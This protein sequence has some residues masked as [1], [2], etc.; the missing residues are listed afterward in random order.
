MRPGGFATFDSP[1]V[2]AEGEEEVRLLDV[3]LDPADS[4][5]EVTDV[6]VAHAG[7]GRSEGET[8][9]RRLRALPQAADLTHDG[10]VTEHCSDE[11]G[12]QAVWVEL[13]QTR[14]GTVR[15]ERSRYL[16]E[17]DGELRRTEWIPRGYRLRVPV[18]AGRE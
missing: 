2:C 7:P 6:G 15:V 9:R 3:E 11:P 14:P 8:A 17:V 4:G 13:H 12:A 1:Y 18:R 10:I 16:Y 5:I